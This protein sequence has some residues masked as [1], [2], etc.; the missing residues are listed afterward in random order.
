MIDKKRK[1]KI[2][3]IA[4]V[5]IFKQCSIITR[6]EQRIHMKNYSGSSGYCQGILLTSFYYSL[7]S[8]VRQSVY[9]DPIIRTHLTALALDLSVSKDV[10][11]GTFFLASFV[12]YCLSAILL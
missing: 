5:Q 4:T 2:K 9:V 11:R 3:S 12:S 6:N 8:D 10:F 7:G 1:E